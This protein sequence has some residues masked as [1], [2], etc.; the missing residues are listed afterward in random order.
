M[1][2]GNSTW[3]RIPLSLVRPHLLGGQENLGGL[4]PKAR[5]AGEW[6][7]LLGT[8]H[9]LLEASRTFR[10]ILG[11]FWD[12]PDTSG[13]LPGPSETVL[14]RSGAIRIVSKTIRVTDRKST[15]LNSSHGYI[16][17]AS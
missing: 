6:V 12:I 11:L 10:D 9:D 13:A 7:V 14:G 15:R 5:G 17:H 4:P 1:G 16:S 8:F 3:R 2:I